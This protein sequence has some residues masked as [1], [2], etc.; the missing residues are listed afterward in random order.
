MFEVDRSYP[1]PESLALEKTKSSGKYNKPDVLYRLRDDFHNKCYLCE[2]KELTSI[3]IEHF[4]AH[5][6]DVDLKFNWDNL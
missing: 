5:R 3:N 6:G 1:D 2:Q 4:V